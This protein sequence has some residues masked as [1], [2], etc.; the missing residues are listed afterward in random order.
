MAPLPQGAAVLSEEKGEGG[1]K[2]GVRREGKEEKEEEEGEGR[3]RE[4]FGR[5]AGE[6]L[7]EEAGEHQ[8]PLLG[9]YI[10]FPGLCVLPLSCCCFPALSCPFPY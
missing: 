3:T 4:V 8:G 6:A 2:G 1:G 7:W 5:R 10:W 9:P